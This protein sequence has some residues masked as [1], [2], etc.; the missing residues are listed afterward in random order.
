MVQDVSTGCP[1]A[2]E[3]AG[4]RSVRNFSYSRTA[5]ELAVLGR[6]GAERVDVQ[7]T[8]ILD[9]DRSAVLHGKS[10]N[11]GVRVERG[12]APCP[13]CDSIEGNTCPPLPFP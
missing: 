3:H 1:T 10:V 7:F 8:E 6:D 11:K 13:S 2:M 4:R 5:A 9:V 12:Y